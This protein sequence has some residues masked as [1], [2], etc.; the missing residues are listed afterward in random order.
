V[1][2]KSI[3]ILGSGWLGL[4]MATALAD[5]GYKVRG[6]G[7][8]A[9]KCQL[10]QSLGIQPFLVDLHRLDLLN[11][12]R[13]LESD[14]LVYTVPPS[15]TS[16]AGLATM[17]EIMQRSGVKEILVTSSTGIYHD[18]NTRITESNAD[19]FLKEESSLF[20]VEDLFVKSGIS[21]TILRLAGLVSE[22]RH[23]GKFARSASTLNNP[24]GRINL[25]HR[26]DVIGVIQAVI[27]NQQ[28]SQVFH[29]CADEHPTKKE[30]YTGA[31]ESIN[32]PIPVFE[33]V[34]ND[35][36]KIIDNTKVKE[37]FN[38]KFRSLNDCLRKI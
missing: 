26:E 21:T 23:P 14:Y 27:E 20:K 15:K 22:D 13:F 8:T 37:T 19:Q 28:G 2:K 17:I 30:F 6:S 32:E 1:K 3:S 5:R 35:G 29:V 24:N 31:A 25:V 34:T 11:V 7:T 12:Q 9:V 4:P 38:F 36:F 18:A 10:I 33:A 16:L